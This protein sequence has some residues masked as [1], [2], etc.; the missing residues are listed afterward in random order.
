[1]KLGSG[2]EQGLDHERNC[3]IDQEKPG[4]EDQRPKTESKCFQKSL[5]KD[6]GW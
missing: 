3:Y 6:Q 1:M 5:L 2:D 4:Y